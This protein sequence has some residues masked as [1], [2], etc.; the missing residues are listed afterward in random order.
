LARRIGAR[1]G[2]IALLTG[3]LLIVAVPAEAADLTPALGPPVVLF[4][5]A[6]AP[7]QAN[8]VTIPKRARAVPVQ[9][10]PLIPPAPAQ[11]GPAPLPRQALPI[12]TEL[13]PLASPAPGSVAAPGDVGKP[14]SG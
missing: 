1:G 12:A 2:S 11:L 14:S 13:Q 5:Q 9:A 4:P 8:T 3:A 6:G 10:K 7:Q